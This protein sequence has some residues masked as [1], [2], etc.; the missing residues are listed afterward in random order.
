MPQIT[1]LNEQPKV[2]L[3]KISLDTVYIHMYLR[4]HGGSI[5]RNID[6][7]EEE[8]TKDSAIE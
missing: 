8:L 3:R 1:S 6:A 4:A 2:A 5:F 7:Y